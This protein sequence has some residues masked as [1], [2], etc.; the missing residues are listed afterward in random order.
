MTGALTPEDRRHLETLFEQAAELPCDEHAAF[1]ER[2][3]G[4]NPALRNELFRLLAGLNGADRLGQIKAE[5]PTRVGE[6]IGPYEL[7]EKVGEGGMGEVYAAQQL[8]PVRRKVAIKLIKAGMDSRQVVA[9]FE[10]ERQALAMMDHPNMAKVLDGGSTDGGQPFF[11]MEFIEGVPILDYCDAQ[12]LDTKARLRLFVMVCHAIQH[13]H[14]KGIIH[15]DIKPSNVQVAVHD[16]V[17]SPKVIDFG[18][19]KAIHSD[20]SMGEALTQHLQLVGTPTYMSPE[21]AGTTE[22]DIDTRSDIYSLGVL[23]YELLT[24]ATPFDSQQLSHANLAEIVRL[25]CEE[26]PHKPSTR[27]ATLG[28]EAT[29]VAMHRRIDGR[30][31]AVDLRG[32]LDWIVMKCL[33]KDRARRYETANALA[34]DIE[35]HLRDQPVTAG[36]PSTAYRMRKFVRR[37]RTLVFATSLVALVLLLGAGGTTWGMLWA[38]DEKERANG[39]TGKAVLAAAEEKKARAAE[40]LRAEE[41]QQ[42]A[43]FQTVQMAKVDAMT[44]GARTRR[45]LLAAVPEDRREELKRAIVGINF[46]NL[47][48]GTLEH[49]LFDPSQQAID[50]QFADQ[51]LVQAQL[52]AAL[53]GAEYEAGLYELAIDPIERSFQILTRRVGAEDPR[54]LCALNAR[55]VLRFAQG[56]Y[57]E[58]EKL[59]RQ[60]VEGL[61][62]VL[63]DEHPSTLNALDCLGD[64]LRKLGRFVEAESCFR[65]VLQARHERL[66]PEDPLAIESMRV[67]GAVLRLQGRFDEAEAC[68][69]DAL[70]RQRAR[71]VDVAGLTLDILNSI[72]V[73]FG[74][75]ERPAQAEPYQREA[76]AGSRLLF[77]DDHPRTLTAMNNLSGVLLN[78]LKFAEAENLA[79]ESVDRHRD[80]LGNQ[81][82][83][84]HLAIADLGAVLASMNRFPE[85]LPLLQEAHAGQSRHK[86]DDPRRWLCTLNNLGLTLRKYGHAPEALLL[87]KEAVKGL[88]DMHP[89]DHP[90]RLAALANLAGARKDLGK[91][92][93]SERDYREVL[94]A[95]LRVDPAGKET[96]MSMDNLGL[97]LHLRGKLDEAKELFER[98][99]AGEQQLLG[100]DH[101]DTL[102]TQLNYSGLLVAQ[103]SLEAGAKHCREAVDG[104]RRQPPTTYVYLLSALNNLGKILLDLHRLPEAEACLRESLQGLRRV[105]PKGH[106]NILGTCFH[107][108]RA[109]MELGRSSEAVPFLLEAS[110]GFRALSQ[111]TV[112]AE[113]QA[114]WQSL[115]TKAQARLEV[116]KQAQAQPGS[117]KR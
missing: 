64:T 61:S 48:M 69:V 8:E 73:L 47:A 85:A 103:G 37:N 99:L 92:E 90:H 15:R 2:A 91:L 7:L 58:A 56:H 21:Q 55:G 114:K 111:N 36:P 52:L 57:T 65:Q 39:E 45:A 14:Q 106:P 51:P 110:E 94:A 29:T 108:G 67:L 100:A 82:P 102:I 53:G 115:A 43:D 27:I 93:E 35:N 13:A 112:G 28:Y 81:H 66:G 77:G 62:L 116:A 71:G 11:V 22:Q 88:R 113:V 76:L 1:V 5:A 31:L 74:D 6:R 44:M 63:G 49:D 98:A 80:V 87:L 97:L 117:G 25:I 4:G 109:L 12:R 54:T 32:D 9:R 96:F 19:A 46:T 101:I 34:A 59:S 18:I 30:R 23:L 10:A 26:T 75:Q 89:G 20:A 24:G 40:S 41:L 84:T 68:L 105:Y 78:Q 42:V 60:A 70:A 104:L 3:C 17:P 72:A 107:A 83:E 50:A 16:G 79:K 38:L 86:D 95:R 33:E